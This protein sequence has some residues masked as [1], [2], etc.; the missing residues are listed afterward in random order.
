MMLGKT[1]NKEQRTKNKEQRPRPKQPSNETRTKNKT[2]KQRDKL[3]DKSKEVALGI[4]QERTSDQE[5]HTFLAATGHSP[6]AT[7]PPFVTRGCSRFPLVSIAPP[8]PP[9]VVCTR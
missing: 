7:S 9:R 5:T 1:K 2:T 6:F 3:K 8:T 4:V